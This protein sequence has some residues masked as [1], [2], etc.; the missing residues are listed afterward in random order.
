MLVDDYVRNTPE[1]RRERLLSIMALI[2]RLYP[3][4]KESMQY[5][6]NLRICRWMGGGCKS[7]ELCVVVY[8][9]ACSP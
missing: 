9:F 3:G 6:I 8:L 5:K 7:K 4:V 1:G 2:R